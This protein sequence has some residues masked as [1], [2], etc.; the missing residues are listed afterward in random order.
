ML[1]R[2]IRHLLDNSLKYTTSGGTVQVNVQMLE[3]ELEISVADSG[4]G[5][6][7]ADQDRLFEKFYRVHGQQDNDSV[8]SGLGLSFV[9]SIIE[10]HG[11]RVWLESQLGQGSTFYFAL[12]AQNK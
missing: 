3:S 10:L 8:G 5:I 6:S 2:A 12:P 1:I 4:V 9:K 11:G 7:R